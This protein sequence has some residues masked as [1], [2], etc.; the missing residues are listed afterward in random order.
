MLHIIA[1]MLHTLK[2]SNVLPAVDFTSDKIYSLHDIK[3]IN[4]FRYKSLVYLNDL[5]TKLDK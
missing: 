3:T 4:D 5:L 2:T 1:K